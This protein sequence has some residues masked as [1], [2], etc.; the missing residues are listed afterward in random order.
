MAYYVTRYWRTKGV[1]CF[2]E[3]AASVSK[4]GYLHVCG[5]YRFTTFSPREFYKDRTSAE[6]EV[7]RLLQIKLKNLKSQIKKLERY[8]IAFINA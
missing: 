7:D 3:N 6:K 2:P 8:K 5:E 4:S 1:L